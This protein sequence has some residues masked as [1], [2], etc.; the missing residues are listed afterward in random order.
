MVDTIK[1]SKVTHLRNQK[2][3][4]KF[5]AVPITFKN[6]ADTKT[7]NATTAAKTVINYQ[8]YVKRVRCLKNL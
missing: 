6:T 8:L 4:A 5:V 1:P 2:S 3:N 7:T